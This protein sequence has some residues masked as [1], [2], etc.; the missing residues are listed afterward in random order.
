MTVA[1]EPNRPDL[2]NE[3][4]RNMDA[5]GALRGAEKMKIGNAPSL[6][7]VP[8]EVSQLPGELWTPSQETGQ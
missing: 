3:E 1:K 6:R 7:R 2:Q 4:L 8:R 5:L